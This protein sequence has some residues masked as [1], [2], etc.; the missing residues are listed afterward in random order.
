VTDT[1]R[2]VLV[3][4]MNVFGHALSPSMLT[5][6][7]DVIDH[8]GLKAVQLRG[9]AQ[10]LKLLDE[11]RIESHGVFSISIGKEASGDSS[12][13]TRNVLDLAIEVDDCMDPAAVEM[14]NAKGDV[15]LRVVGLSVSGV[16]CLPTV[17]TASPRE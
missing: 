8:Y 17:P 10:Q 14:R 11:V 2:V 16:C 13:V 5:M 4:E 9:P 12:S 3:A 6:F 1:I 15:V 7:S